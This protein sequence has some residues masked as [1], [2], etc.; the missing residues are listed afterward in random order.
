MHELSGDCRLGEGDLAR[1]R[2]TIA[3]VI[4]PSGT[5]SSTMR[6]SSSDQVCWKL[7]MPSTRV[8]C[9]ICQDSSVSSRNAARGSRA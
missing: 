2:A 4:S 8:E 3:G 5:R 6:S 9:G 1:A 7:V